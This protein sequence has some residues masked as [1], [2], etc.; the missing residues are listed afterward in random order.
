MKEY[1]KQ[2]QKDNKD[3]IKEYRKEYYKLKKLKCIDD[4]FNNL[5]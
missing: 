4:T 3:K 1:Q 5:P 2:Y